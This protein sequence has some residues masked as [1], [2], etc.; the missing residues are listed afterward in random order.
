MEL[1]AR[2]VEELER[3]Q[4]QMAEMLK[5]DEQV[6]FHKKKKFTSAMRRIAPDGLATT[7]GWTAN[8]RTIRHVLEMRT[9]EGAEEEIRLVFGKVGEIVTKRYPNMFGDYK[10]EIL[11]GLPCYKTENRKV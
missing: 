1:M 6:S 5:L 2:T 9:E 3:L 10:V 11:D 7:I 8:F 4:L